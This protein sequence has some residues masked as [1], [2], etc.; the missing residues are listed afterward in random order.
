MKK[1]L[2]LV[3]AS[4]VAVMLSACGPDDTKGGNS[5]N[6]QNGDLIPNTSDNSSGGSLTSDIMESMPNGSAV[7]PGTNTP[8]DSSKSNQFD[9]K[10]S[11]DKAIEIALNSAGINKDNAFD[12]DVELDRELGVTVWDIDFETMDMEYSYEINAETGKIVRQN[13]ER[14]D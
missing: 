12:F 5:N 9:T 1:I 3:L 2:L 11:R 10:I 13:K 8:T 7:N 6:N 4:V 14:N